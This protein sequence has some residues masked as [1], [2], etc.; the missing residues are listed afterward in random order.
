MTIRAIL[1]CAALAGLAAPEAPA[2]AAQD[3]RGPT[4]IDPAG[5]WQLDMAENNCRLARAFGTEEKKTLFLLEQWD[6]ST[7]VS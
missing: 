5:P 1:A 3:D 2:F 4:V 7:E 6:P